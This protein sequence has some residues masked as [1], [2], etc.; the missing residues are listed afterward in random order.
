MRDGPCQP[1]SAPLRGGLEAGGWRRDRYGPP[2]GAGHTRPGKLGRAAFPEGREDRL[3]PLSRQ[4]GTGKRGLMLR[5]KSLG[6][7]RSA[8]AAVKPGPSF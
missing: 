8:T 4:H 6:G 5:P 7:L 1:P 3:A 2:S